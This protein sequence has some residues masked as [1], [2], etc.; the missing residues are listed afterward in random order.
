MVGLS[1][2]EKKSDSLNVISPGMSISNRCIYEEH[3]CPF[4]SSKCDIIK[5]FQ[6]MLHML[7]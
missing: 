7:L 2:A 4:K 1:P 6:S 3:N 5:T